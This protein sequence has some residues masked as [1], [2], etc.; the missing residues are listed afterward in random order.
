MGPLPQGQ[1][2]DWLRVWS[3]TAALLD[4]YRVAGLE[5]LLTEDVVRF[6][7]IQQLASL[8][9]RA[10]RIE[11]EWRRAGVT[12]AVDLVVTGAVPAAVEFKFPREPKETNAAWTQHLGQA[13]KDFYRLAFMPAEFADRWCV[14][15][16]SRRMRRYLDSTAERYGVRLG[17]TVGA[18][19]VLEPALVERLPGTARR[20]LV[21]WD[22]R[23]ATVRAVC[24]AALPVG[25][26]LLL[27]A[28]SV[29]PV[30]G[31][32]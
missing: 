31:P 32:N 14:Q 30:V 26:D 28:H 25:D 15:L 1:Q 9:V 8:G 2:P 7:T 5:S 21:R 10:F 11:P 22:E 3:L 27:V 20:E 6:A 19:T 4:S 16:L 24:V 29:Q 13:L 12:D 17:A 23:L 18:A